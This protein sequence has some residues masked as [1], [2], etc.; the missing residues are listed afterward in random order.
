MFGLGASVSAP[1]HDVS[2][3]NIYRE[4][5]GFKKINFEIIL[6]VGTP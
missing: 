6:I 5:L 1:K 4:I 3:E 2:T